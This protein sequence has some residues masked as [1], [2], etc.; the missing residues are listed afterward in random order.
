MSLSSFTRPDLG[1]RGSRHGMKL[2]R[3]RSNVLTLTLTSQELA[4]LFAAVRIALD[5]LHA[6]PETPRQSLAFL[7]H[8]VRDYTHAVERL[9]DGSGS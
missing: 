2:A 8:L 6:N 4:A 1:P 9:Y 3:S 5:A 7:E